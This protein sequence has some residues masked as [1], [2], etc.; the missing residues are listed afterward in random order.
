MRTGVQQSLQDRSGKRRRHAVD[1]RRQAG[2]AALRRAVVLA[3]R[4]EDDLHVRQRPLRCARRRDPPP[5]LLERRV[6]LDRISPD[7]KWVTLAKILPDPVGGP[8]P[9]FICVG[10][11]IP[12]LFIRPAGPGKL[13]TVARAVAT[14]GWWRGRLLI[15]Q[16]KSV[17]EGQSICLLRSTPTTTA[18]ATSRSTRSVTSGG[19]PARR[20][21]ATS[22]PPR[23]LAQGRTSRRRSSTGTSRS[24]HPGTAQLVRNLTHGQHDSY[25]TWSP[26]SSLIAFN[27]GHSIYVIHADGSDAGRPRLLV[28]SGIQPTWGA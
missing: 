3:Q 23:L 9:G 21:A 19:P 2:R 18:R 7:G 1:A 25:P 17:E 14:V 8:C 12:Y 11:S 5:K 28:R 27:R 15:D 16:Q 10:R 4:H 26:D 13:E 24:I 22:P 6:V 20:T